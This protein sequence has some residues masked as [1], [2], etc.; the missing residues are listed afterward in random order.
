[1]ITYRGFE[2]YNVGETIN[3]IYDSGQQDEVNIDTEASHDSGTRVW[4]AT[5][6][7]YLLLSPFVAGYLYTV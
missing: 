4:H 3:R 1:M 6:S 2:I 5:L 7:S